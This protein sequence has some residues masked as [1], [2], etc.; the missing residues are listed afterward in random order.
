MA[1]RW[2]PKPLVAVRVRAPRPINYEEIMERRKFI[3]GAGLVS[4][5][6]GGVFAGKVVVEKIHTKEVIKEVLPPVEEVDISHLAP[7]SPTSLVLRGNPKP[8]T[9]SN[10]GSNGIGG[11]LYTNPAD[12][13]NRVEL[14]VGKD[15]RLWIK[16]GDE[17]KRVT[18]DC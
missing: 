2:S 4:G 9:Y 17:W 16:I 3:R 18:V 10:Q 13:Q 6:L 15:N 8:K 5:F 7:E 1:E 11:F 14:S 12:Y